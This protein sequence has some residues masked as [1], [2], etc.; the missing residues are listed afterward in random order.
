MKI[1]LTKEQVSQFL[2]DNYISIKMGDYELYF[3][4]G[5]YDNTPC[6]FEIIQKKNNKTLKMYAHET[7]ELELLKPKRPHDPS[8]WHNDPLCP[9]CGTYMIYN[10]EHCPK[11][12]QKI[13]WSEK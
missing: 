12:G 11:C 13:D 1:E 2:E 4:T 8:Y 3:G 7:N 9:N 6:Y 5:N 10:F